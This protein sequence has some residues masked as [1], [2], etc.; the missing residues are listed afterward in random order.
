MS[1]VKW[2]RTI[3]ANSNEIIF[4]GVFNPD[5]E[6]EE[7]HNFDGP[8][9]TI[10]ELWYSKPS[11]NTQAFRAFDDA[12]EEIEPGWDGS[13]DTPLPP[14]KHY[15]KV[16]ATKLAKSVD[17]HFSRPSDTETEVEDYETGAPS[18][19][20]QEK[21][22]VERSFTIAT[23]CHKVK[24]T[25]RSSSAQLKKKKQASWSGNLLSLFHPQKLRRSYEILRSASV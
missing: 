20:R 25:S 15:Y 21:T 19:T 18:L 10:T 8:M 4:E 1:H 12:L 17:D 2:R 22:A 23:S 5:N 9:N 14:S 3:D 13:E 16:Y 11:R 6:D 24:S 7:K